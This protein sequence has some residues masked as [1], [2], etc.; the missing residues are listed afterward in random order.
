MART[1]ECS[2][3]EQH[4]ICQVCDDEGEGLPPSPEKYISMEARYDGWCAAE[5]C[6]EGARAILAGEPMYMVVDVDDDKRYLHHSC[7]ENEKSRH[8]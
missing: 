7:G 1:R 5:T 4:I 3:T 8:V 6:D 2:H